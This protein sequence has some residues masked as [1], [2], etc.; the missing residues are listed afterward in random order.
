VELARQ[1]D[2]FRARG[3]EVASIIPEPPDVL[4]AFARKHGLGIPLLSDEGAAI[5]RRAGLLDETAGGGKSVPY[6][7]SLM[8]DAE[9]RVV[10]RFFEEE[11]ENRRT[12]G[13]ILAAQGESGLRPRQVAATHFTAEA[14][15]SN[16]VIAP[17]QLLTLIVDI[18]MK[19]GFHAYAPGAAGYRVIDVTLDESPLWQPHPTRV[20]PGHPE[21]LAG[22]REPVPVLEGR[23][24]VL[25]DVTQLFRAGLPLLKDQPQVPVAIT[26]RLEYQVC[27]ATV[28]YPPSSLPLRW[29]LGLRRWTR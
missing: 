29:D 23:F 28:C 18:E 13:S 1:A 26:G 17:G 15:V 6:A 7:G 25:K 4:L 20:P 27:S 3:I 19:P 12:A 5:I 8:L 21:R 24:R 14:S 16:D 9:G 10:S 2:K 22:S 11:T